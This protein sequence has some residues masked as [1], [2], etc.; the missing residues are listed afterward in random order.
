MFKL[1][2]IFNT[3]GNYMR[4]FSYDPFHYHF[5]YVDDVKLWSREIFNENG[6]PVKIRRIKKLK[7]NNDLKIVFASVKITE[8]LDFIRAMREL[9]TQMILAGS[10]DYLDVC[11]NFRKKCI[12]KA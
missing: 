7:S 6:T 2:R 4:M 12:M 3:S 5:A 11:D 1:C 10:K 8:Q 9:K